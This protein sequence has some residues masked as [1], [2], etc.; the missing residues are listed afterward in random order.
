MIGYVS[1][2]EL[3]HDPDNLTTFQPLPMGF[4]TRSNKAKKYDVKFRALH[5]DYIQSF[6]FVHPFVHIDPTEVPVVELDYFHGSFFNNRLCNT[7]YP[8]FIAFTKADAVRMFK[9]LIDW[10]QLSPNIH[11]DGFV[12]VEMFPETVH[13]VQKRVQDMLGKFEEGKTFIVFR[14]V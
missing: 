13:E 12:S 7:F 6:R 1:M 10:K 8:Q 11:G 4:S 3:T 5:K 14:G 2:F 9:Q